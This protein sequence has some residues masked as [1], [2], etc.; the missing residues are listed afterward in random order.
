MVVVPRRHRNR[1][2]RVRRRAATQ[3]PVSTP[4]RTITATPSSMESSRCTASRCEPPT[5]AHPGARRRAQVRL[6]ARLPDLAIRRWLTQGGFLAGLAG[7]RAARSG[8]VLDRPAWTTVRA[9]PRASRSRT[10]F[11]AQ[12]AWQASSG[13]ASSDLRKGVDY[14]EAQP[15]CRHNIAYAGVSLG[16][17]H[18]HAHRRRGPADQRPS[19]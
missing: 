6:G 15:F 9:H 10:R 1:H 17:H 18:R 13:A 5:G 7:R 3:R 11:R 12:P 16:R 14:L 4:P 2:R 19:C 8:D